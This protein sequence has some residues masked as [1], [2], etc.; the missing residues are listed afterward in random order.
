MSTHI[1]ML[2]KDMTPQQLAMAESEFNNKK[3][4]KLIAFLLWFFLSPFAA[5]RF[6]IGDTG[7]AIFMILFGWATL[8]I[9]PLVDIIFTIMKI[10]KINEETEYEILQRVKA[11]A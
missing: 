7:R 1:M 11:V 10:D 3:K 8:M 6:Y 9:W 5:Q 4:D 2:K